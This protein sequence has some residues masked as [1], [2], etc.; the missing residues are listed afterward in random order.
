MNKPARL[1]NRERVARWR[2]ALREQG[3]RPKQIWVPDLRSA[4]FKEQAR[5]E[6]LAVA[7]A[8]READDQAFI[9]SLFDWESLAPYDAPLPE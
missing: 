8:D 1:S 6:A 3:L 9:D 7:A 5:R 2:A 4:E